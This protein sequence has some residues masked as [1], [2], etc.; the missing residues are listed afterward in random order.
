MAINNHVQIEGNVGS[1]PEVKHNPNGSVVANFSIA[2][3]DSWKDKKTGDWKEV[4]TWV[5]VTCWGEFAQSIERKVS[6][7][8]TITVKG[9]LRNESWVDKEGK[10]HVKT[11]IQCE[12][13]R[14]YTPAKA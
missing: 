6:K 8:T 3:T 11:Y 5:N 10:R 7:G 2:T 1:D 14:I 9:Q 4:V 12:E 13:F